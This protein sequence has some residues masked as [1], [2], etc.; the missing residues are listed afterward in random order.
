MVRAVPGKLVGAIRKVSGKNLIRAFP[1][2]SHGGMRLAHAGE[3]PHRQRAR[4]GARL[5][6]VVREL[7]DRALQVLLRVQVEL[8]MIGSIV[9]Y[10]ALDMCSVSSKLRP[11]KEIEKVFRRAWLV[12]AA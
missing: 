5:I 8:L 1:A 4:I 12:L 11:L 6:G 10:H 9:R 7:L 3:K 2:Q